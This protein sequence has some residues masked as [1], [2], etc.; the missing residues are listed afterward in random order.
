MTRLTIDSLCILRLC[1]AFVL[2]ISCSGEQS[3]PANPPD[4][5]APDAAAPTAPRIDHLTAAAGENRTIG[6]T[7]EGRTAGAAPVMIALAVLDG[8]G[9]VMSD[10]DYSLGFD[11][12]PNR[13]QAVSFASHLETD[14]AAFSGFFGLQ[15]QE[16]AGTPAA[17]RVAFMDSTQTWGE[18]VEALV[19]VPVRAMLAVGEACDY[20]QT[21]NVCPGGAFCESPDGTFERMTCQQPSATCPSSLPVLEGV[22]RGSNRDSP[23]ATV[24]S[25][26]L[27]RG[28]LGNEQG[29]TFTAPR[30]GRFR[31]TAQSDGNYALTLFVRRYCHL[32]RGGDSEVA[33]AHEN[34]DDVLPPTLE[35]ELASGQTVY[36][37]VE[38][39]WANGG[40]YVLSVE[41]DSI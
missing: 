14:A 22:Y 27:S 32:A 18:A 7:F 23:D 28:N 34:D 31:F 4:A 36:V 13:H 26:T 8:A 30:T 21:L 11:V 40:D 6:V 39:W 35:L 12:R 9:V 10:G 19:T 15:D 17:V 20:F 16:I 38:A 33:C 29:H 41:D 37:F 3:A 5:A 24:A 25:C 2:A 1:A